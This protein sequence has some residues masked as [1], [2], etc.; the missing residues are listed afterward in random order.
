[1]LMML[2]TNHAPVVIMKIALKGPGMYSPPER[3]EEALE[4][5]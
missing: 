5:E 3:V 2:W 1:M 4:V